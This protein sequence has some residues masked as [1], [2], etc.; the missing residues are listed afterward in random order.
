MLRYSG[1][2]LVIRKLE[3]LGI[4]LLIH[5]PQPIRVAAHLGRRVPYLTVTVDRRKS[6]VHDTAHGTLQF[7]DLKML[8]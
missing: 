8:D 6:F 4:R 2:S 5:S 7:S 1:I 3:V